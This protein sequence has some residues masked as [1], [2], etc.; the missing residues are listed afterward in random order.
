MNIANAAPCFGSMIQ[1]PY[2]PYGPYGE[3]IITNWIVNDDID[4]VDFNENPVNPIEIQN[5]FLPGCWVIVQVT[6]TL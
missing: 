6:P 5:V 4:V 3:G 2:L 1:V